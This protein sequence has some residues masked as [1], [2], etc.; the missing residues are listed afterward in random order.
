[1]DE[2]IKLIDEKIEKIK[3]TAEEEA[4]KDSAAE[5]KADVILNGLATGAYYS[6]DSS[7]FINITG[8]SSSNAEC[9]FYMVN[10]EYKNVCGYTS[11]FSAATAGRQFSASFPKANWYYYNNGNKTEAPDI[12]NVKGSYSGGKITLEGSNI[13]YTKSR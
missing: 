1:M 10:C 4:K 12:L 6:P 3:R 8:T 7:S 13:T 9:T 2:N 11:T 5:S